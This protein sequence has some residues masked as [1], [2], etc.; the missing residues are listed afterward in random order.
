MKALR[1]IFIFTI[2][3]S[4]GGGHIF[5]P[6]LGTERRGVQFMDIAIVQDI[7][8][9]MAVTE[10]VKQ[11]LEVL[12][13]DNA[14]WARRREEKDLIKLI[15]RVKEMETDV[16]MMMSHFVCVSRRDEGGRITEGLCHAFACLNNLFQDLKKARKDLN[17]AYIHPEEIKQMEIDWGRFMKTITQIQK[18]LHHGK[19][20]AGDDVLLSSKE[21]ERNGPFPEAC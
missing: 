11:A 13:G 9:L 3:R 16:S 6:T 12:E 20:Y 19:T 1:C 17:D 15:D 4:L 8:N 5:V 10:N 18:H 14:V 7:R 21:E 2:K